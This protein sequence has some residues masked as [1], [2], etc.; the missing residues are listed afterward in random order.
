MTRTTGLRPLASF[1]LIAGACTL[2]AP[3]QPGRSDEPAKL[4]LLFLGY[5]GHHRPELFAKLLE[6]AL[7][8]EGIA[9]TYSD[10]VAS[11]TPQKLATLDAVAI[12]RDSGDLP[13]A[14]EAALVSF[15]EN[16]KGLVAIH[17]ASH[18]F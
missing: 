9:I 18:C 8:K 12:F 16:G 15:V 5:N 2:L 1:V 6:P 17:C 4:Q 13:P 14:E 11:L 10:N 3:G 7:A